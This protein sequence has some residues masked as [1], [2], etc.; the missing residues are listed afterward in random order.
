MP[1]SFALPA[2]W[3]AV[4]AAQ[5]QG[6]DLAWE[7]SELAKLAG[8][9]AA[10]ERLF[11]A[12][13]QVRL[14]E[15]LGHTRLATEGPA[16]PAWL[17]ALG[18][19]PAGL[20][21]EPGLAGFV[22]GPDEITPLVEGEGWIAT[23]RSVELERRFAAAILARLSDVGAVDVPDALLDAPIELNS[24]QRSAVRLAARS[25]LAVVTGGPG[26][27]KTSIVAALLRVFA[28]AAIALTAPTGKAAQRMGLAVP[29][30]EPLTLHRLLGWRSRR[31][32]WRHHA[33]HPLA[34]DLVI[35]DEASMVDQELMAR[36]LDALK[37]EARLVLLGDADQLPSV[38][39][40]AV[41]RDL[42]GALPAVVAR[43]EKSYRMDASDQAGR[44]IL[45]YAKQVRGGIAEETGLP[46]RLSVEA[47]AGQGVELLRPDALPEL[48]KAWR[49]RITALEG[50]EA[51]V[52]IE[53]AC[54]ATG[55]E[56]ASTA[57]MQALMDHHGRFR[58]LALLQEGPSLTGAADLNA[59]LHTL[60][61]PLNGRGLQRDLPFYSGEPVMMVRNDYGRGLFNGDQGLVVKVRREGAGR[62]EVVFWKE[63]RPV[64]FSLGSLMPDLTLAYALTVH[65]AQGSEFDAVAVVLPS[66]DHPLLT[67]QNLYT[68][69]TRARKHALIVGDPALP[70]LASRKEERRVTGLVELLTQSRSR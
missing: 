23:G 3:A 22:G 4:L 45:S 21:V 25:R 51:L 36:L 50:Y 24:E 42:V 40:G 52:R 26:T 5:G 19:L 7:P 46:V 37:P 27:G 56:P 32:D 1:E 11:H 44:A 58:L 18:P 33:G 65:K 53:H 67:R 9:G 61:W 20:K 2:S 69:L 54:D 64:A 31:G 48:V 59:A 29:G 14:A 35:V 63:G 17:G 38:G 41:L 8:E 12:A 16:A 28:G 55:F 13:L 70:P 34:A 57:A 10:A 66:A 68:A 30:L 6:L 43:L 15:T 60:A 47:M 49:A 62:R 39:S